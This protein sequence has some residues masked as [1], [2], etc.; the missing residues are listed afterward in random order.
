MSVHPLHFHLQITHAPHPTQT[1]L[2]GWQGRGKVGFR[3][4][5]KGNR[6]ADQRKFKR[7]LTFIKRDLYY[8]RMRCNS[9]ML[10]GLLKAAWPRFSCTV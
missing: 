3:P 9:V 2:L 8:E 6:L 10:L 5:A 7:S 4:P 1:H